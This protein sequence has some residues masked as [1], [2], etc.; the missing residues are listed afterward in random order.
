VPVEIALTPLDQRDGRL[1]LTSIIDIT[2]R[3]LVERALRENEARYRE[4]FSNSPVALLE[5]DFSEARNYLQGVMGEPVADLDAW[6]DAHADVLR[7]AL[8]KVK[9]VMAN[10]RALELL[11][12]DSTESLESLSSFFVPETASWFRAGV[13]ALLLGER[14]FGLET[15]TRTLRSGRRVVSKR[16]HVLPGHEQTWSRVVVSLFDLTLHKDAE[17][18]LRTSLHEKEMLLRE[19]HHRVKNNL[20]IISSLLNMKADA[21]D[22]TVSQQ[23]FVDCQ[24]RIQSLAFVHEHLY[25]SADVSHVP[26]GDYARTLVDHLKRSCRK[27]GLSV[28]TLIEIE[29]IDLSIDD[30]I[31]CGLIVNELVTNA[32]K[33]AFA[34]PGSGSIEILMHRCDGGL[35]ELV[36][37]DDGRGLPRALDPRNSGTLG[38]ELVYTFAEQLRA[39]VQI[40]GEPGTSVAIRFTPGSTARLSH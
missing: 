31:P 34:I 19:I 7:G 6:L 10:Q 14:Y 32:L 21:L 38:L 3:K 35:V 2:E 36:V 11:E 4:L 12:A 26:F 1:V 28:Q 16:L 27:P 13:R 37:K 30:A 33:H 15:V 40:S 5:Q 25:V 17:L 18:Q 39:S 29:E 9:T 8:C 22:S 23:V 24:A 20:Q